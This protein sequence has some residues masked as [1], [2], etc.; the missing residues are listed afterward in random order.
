MTANHDNVLQWL[1]QTHLDVEAMRQHIH[2]VAYTPFHLLKEAYGHFLR[3]LH[4]INTARMEYLLTARWWTEG[5]VQL[6]ATANT[7][8]EDIHM[9]NVQRARVMAT[10]GF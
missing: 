8:L 10:N 6:I 7:T 2:G 4:S 3:A 1:V 5:T 9:T